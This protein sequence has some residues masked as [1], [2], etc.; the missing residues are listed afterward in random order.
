MHQRFT[1][2]HVDG[3]WVYDPKLE[4][5]S[6]DGGVVRYAYPCNPP[7]PPCQYC[8]GVS[9]RQDIHGPR[10]DAHIMGHS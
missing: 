10:C 3:T 9:S 8:G 5:W 2:S 7:M 6:K 1:P 4:R